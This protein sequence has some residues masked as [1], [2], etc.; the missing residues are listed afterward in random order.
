MIEDLCNIERTDYFGNFG[1]RLAW[2]KVIPRPLQEVE[3]FLKIKTD[4]KTSDP[5]P[6]IPN[7]IYNPI[8]PSPP[9]LKRLLISDLPSKSPNEFSECTRSY[10]LLI[11][12]QKE[13][14]IQTD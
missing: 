3:T 4:G 13:I 7:K 10:Y 11:Q 9:P 12:A 5:H 1:V 8:P 14:T 6:H 2:D